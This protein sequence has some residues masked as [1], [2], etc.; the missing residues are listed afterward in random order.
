MKREEFEHVLRAAAVVIGE[1]EFVVVGS[2]A[3]LGQFLDPPE[4]LLRSLEVDLYPRQD[5]S[6]ADEID[7]ALGD[8]SRFHETYDYYAHGVGPE[9]A[10][11]PAGWEGRLVAVTLK[12]PT[13]DPVTAWCL[14]IH[15]LVLAKL[16]AGRPHDFEFAEVAVE[17]GL[18]EPQQLRLGLEL[19]SAGDRRVVRERLEGLLRRLSSPR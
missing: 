13:K 2:Q 1:D 8:G 9:T 6:R 12:P 5:P 4:A 11:A 15:D 16:A 14:E 3:V 7:G 17:A 10:R 18:A 19:M